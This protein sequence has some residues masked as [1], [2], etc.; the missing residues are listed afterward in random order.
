MHLEIPELLGRLGLQDLLDLL[1]FQEAL[2]QQGPQD[3]RVLQASLVQMA[4]Q[5]PRVLPGHREPLVRR[6]LR[7]VL[8]Q[9]ASQD[10]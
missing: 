3:H 1:D 4:S 8:D 5:D 7:E 9:Q 6:V 10:H 2:A